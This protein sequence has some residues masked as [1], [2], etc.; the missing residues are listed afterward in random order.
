[1]NSRKIAFISLMSALGLLLSALSLNMA[2]IFSAVGQGGA[3][4]DFSHT[5]TFIA[6]IFGGPS[7]GIAVG[8]LG[9]IYAGFHFGYVMGSL[10]LLSLFGV[11][12]GKA[13]TGL[14]AGLL[15]KKL[16]IN[17]R[18]RI[19]ILTVLTVLASYIPECIFTIMYF[20][21]LVPI[22]YGFSMSF[23]VPI[24]I[25]KA[26]VEIVVMSFLMGALVGNNGFKEFVAKFLLTTK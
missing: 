19:S 26:W 18:K 23:L 16:R 11:P 5:A 14:T 7:A 25:S 2:P 13:L 21:Y 1:M 10:G 17:E 15:Y 24:V 22:F 20:L 4:L 9:G 6:S 3:A 8:L 12:L